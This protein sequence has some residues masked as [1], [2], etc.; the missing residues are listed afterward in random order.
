MM[1]SNISILVIARTTKIFVVNVR[2]N[3]SFTNVSITLTYI[4]HSYLMKDEHSEQIN[5]VSFYND[6][7]NNRTAKVELDNFQLNPPLGLSCLD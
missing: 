4:R 1:I 2:S 3:S 5:G 7:W 6:Y